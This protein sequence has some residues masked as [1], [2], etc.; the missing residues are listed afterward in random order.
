[1]EL[2]LV[3]LQAIR[4]EFFSYLEDD[5]QEE[6]KAKLVQLRNTG[7]YQTA[8][9]REM[10]GRPVYAGKYWTLFDGFD[11]AQHI[12]ADEVCLI[13]EACRDKKNKKTFGDRTTALRKWYS[14]L[15]E[16]KVEEAK[17]A[18]EKWNQEGA[19]DKDRMHM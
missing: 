2:L 14:K 4:E 17:K 16:S 11:A 1:M 7:E 18:A 13:D 5:E 19:P 9:E 6:E 8:E 12:F 3:I 15:P 10:A